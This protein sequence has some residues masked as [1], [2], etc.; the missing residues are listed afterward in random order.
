MYLKRLITVSGNRILKSQ[1][2]FIVIRYFFFTF[3]KALKW[4]ADR[5]L[6]GPKKKI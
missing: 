4:I 5:I 3:G 2:T 1:N 6:A